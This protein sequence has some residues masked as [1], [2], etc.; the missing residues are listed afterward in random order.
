[1]TRAGAIAPWMAL[2]ALAAWVAAPSGWL[3][4][5]AAV[6][7]ALGAVGIPPG[8]RVVWHLGV[9]LSL[10]AVVAGFQA[11]RQVDALL[12]DWEGY[13]GEREAEVGEILAARL[14]RRQTLAETAADVLAEKALDPT[15]PVDLAFVSALRARHGLAALAL[16]DANGRLILW[17]GAHWGKVPE[18][19][20][21]GFLRHTYLDRPLFGYLYVTALTEDGR[22]AV[23]ADLLRADLPDV[24]EAGVQDFSS[25]F[26][27]DVGE[28]VRVTQHDPGS[29]EGV[30]DL[31]L[32]DRRLMSVVVDR[33]RPEVRAREVGDGWRVRV[34]VL[35][36]S[37]WGLLALG[38]GP[39]RAGAMAGAAVLLLVAALLPAGEV[40]GL[41]RLF[42]TRLL[43]LWGGA[44]AAPGRVVLLVLALT[45]LL[46]ALPLGRRRL[47]V[48]AAAAV[49]AVLYP[50]FLGWVG[51]GE[52]VGTL[53]EGRPEWVAF[54]AAVAL[55]LAL[56]TTALMTSVRP[57]NR[58]VWRG[59]AAVAVALVLGGGSGAW[60]WLTAGVP[61]GWWGLWAA[62]VALA[63][64]TGGSLR[65]WRRGVAVGGVAVTL[66]G[67]AAVPATWSFS[68]STAMEEGVERLEG[69]VSREDP[70]LARGL[71]RLAVAADSL[72]RAGREGV[73][74]LYHAWRASGL[75]G[76][77]YPVRLTRWAPDGFRGV[78]LRVGAEGILPGV[79][80]TLLAEQQGLPDPR[81]LRL[82]RDD[83][84]Y[85][86]T[87][88]LSD[89]GV[90]SVVAPPFS[91][92]TRPS[93]LDPFVRVRGTS[94]GGT[95]SFIS[96]LPGDTRAGA[97]L[98][99]VRDGSTWRAEVGV[100]F[101]NDRAYYAHHTVALPGPLQAVAR[102]TL[103]LVLDGLL[104]GTFWFLGAVV[105]AR[106]GTGPVL[107][108]PTSISFRARVTWALFGFFALAIS[109][110]GTVA[111]RTVAQASYRSAE[112]IA[113]R[114]VDDAA[115]WYRTLAGGMDRLARQV[116]SDLVVYRGGELAEGSV[117]ELV[118]LGL[119]EAW[120][121]YPV[122]QAID[123][124]A[125]IKRF[126][127]T[128][129]GRWA[130]VTAFRRLPDGD[131]L[132]AQVPLRAGTAA[133]QA[134]DLLE[135]LG[136]FVA[137]GAALSFALAMVA[138]RWLTRPIHALQVASERVGSG[139]LDL[140]L[141][142]NRTDEFGAV[143]RA[144]NRMVERVRRARRQLVRTSRRTQLI[145]DEAAVGM[146]AVDPRGRITLVNPRA[147][148]LLGAA[149]VLGEPLRRDG[150]LETELAGW[151]E[152]YLAGEADRADHELQ[153]GDRRIRVRTRRLGSRGARRGAVV[154]M[155]DVTDE[156]RAERVLAWGEMARQ[157]AHEVKNPLTPIKLS[158]QHVR[159]AWQDGRPD[160]EDI[161]LRNA[162]AM[163][164]EIDR[165]A[166]IAQS[167]SRF[168]APAEAG[169]PLAP[170]SLPLVVGDVM[171]L[172]GSSVASVRFS[173]DVPGD[174]PAVVSRTPELKEVLVN[175]LENARFAS[176]EGDRVEVR[177]R[178]DG[179]GVVL[180]VI[181][182]GV[183]IPEDV[184]PRIFEPQFST[185]STGSGLGL[186]IVRR[187]V[188]SWGGEVEARSRVGEG[189]VVRVTLRPWTVEGDRPAGVG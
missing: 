116:G 174:L 46:G 80:P 183:G 156:L 38:V 155:D 76:G 33:P 5:V 182:E 163:L 167:F 20:Q 129:L 189:T 77:G 97:P 40:P 59:W 111:Y 67:T 1:M 187:L 112:V 186:A 78:E 90:L 149:V 3:L 153:S 23:A 42:D 91:E 114:V 158:I 178:M 115:V 57:G 37:A 70:A 62:P 44:G 45:T 132:A 58:A 64:G 88:P 119:Y 150:P 109:L 14:E 143:F 108:L 162:E 103:L 9:I 151:L 54:Q 168:G 110:F 28:R 121:P 89:G 24:L 145:M 75:A 102:A 73:D 39:V 49:S 27:G 68:V 172:Y 41:G 96:L 131:I 34:T 177:A 81:L 173:H 185:R 140:R 135:L 83:A 43:P 55:V 113:E 169:I 180:E 16:Y 127:G 12:S 144:F 71:E 82:N 176:D 101:A 164:T 30:W 107:W 26:F 7:G 130:Y 142:E 4:A 95:M 22:V 123:S 31:S 2:A 69:L 175:L 6:A 159:R 17:D 18:S 118:E 79:L 32:P 65:G 106:G 66:A 126:T 181:D 13:W 170:V 100:R 72:D 63:A 25:R 154:A 8:R 10:V 120:T 133:I 122:Q 52:A 99:W 21:G 53:V 93:S 50:A 85:V 125:G 165:L 61:L 146:L 35:L 179:D 60:V 124:L 94:S 74:V 139:N 84:R 166:A 171:A 157:V 134:T 56:A 136:F 128:E 15:D 86:L 138:G 92:Q 29:T 48:W 148:E 184:L 19:V 51:R 47:S 161:L 98:S 141:P 147:S 160:F 87:V 105:L 188:R 117:E 36:L 11:H 152:R 137:L 104:L